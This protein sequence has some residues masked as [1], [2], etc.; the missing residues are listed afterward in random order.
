MTPRPR[1]PQGL[2]FN[3]SNHTYR[4]DGR[5]VPGVTGILNKGLPKPAIPYWAAR[6]VAE[7]VIDNPDGV[8]Q[9]R[10]M[11]R[12]PAVAALKQIPWQRRDEAAVRGTDIHAL[13]ERVAHGETVDVP[14]HLHTH[15]DG[16][17]RWLDAFDVQPVLTER[18]CAHRAHW[19]GGTF[20]AVVTI[21]GT[22]WILD[23]KTSTGVYGETALQTA[24]Y[25]SAEF[26][27]DGDTE[28]PMPAIERTGVVHI[29][30]TGTTLHPLAVD[31]DGIAYDY[32]IFRHIAY[33]AARTDHIKSRVG[34][35]IE[36]PT[37]MSEVATTAV[38]GD[39]P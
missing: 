11:G 5:P 9:L 28:H 1:P 27:A 2:T 22:V 24:A 19:W 38:R 8:D 37:H 10:T 25:A 26:Y 13:A 33:V 34:A 21:G 16:Y 6:T 23:W 17:A 7:Y 20:D 14:E 31:P 35:A 29:T 3:A 18:P 36:E 30:D 39:Q 12:G 15:V 32:G 4:L